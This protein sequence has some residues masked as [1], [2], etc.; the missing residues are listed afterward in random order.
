M[1]VVTKAEWLEEALRQA[2]PVMEWEIEEVTR[3]IA[4]QSVRAQGRRLDRAQTG[5]PVPLRLVS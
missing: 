2:P 1:A 4:R 3:L 5:E